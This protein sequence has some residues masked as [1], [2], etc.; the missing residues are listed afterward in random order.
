LFDDWRPDAVDIDVTLVVADIEA[1]SRELGVLVY[2]VE[3]VEPR[4][5]VK[6]SLTPV[7]FLGVFSWA[8]TCTN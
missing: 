7:D 2:V 6:L 5:G 3:E 1:E 8:I 4:F